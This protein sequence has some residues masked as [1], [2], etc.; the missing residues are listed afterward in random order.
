MTRFRQHWMAMD[1]QHRRCDTNGRTASRWSSCYSAGCRMEGH[2]WRKLYCHSDGC[3]GYFFGSSVRCPAMGA[4]HP[5]LLECHDDQQQ[6][7]DADISRSP[8]K[9]WIDCER[10][11]ASGREF[12]SVMVR[13]KNEYLK[14]PV[15]TGNDTNLF[16]LEALVCR[17]D[18]EK[19]PKNY[20]SPYD[21]IR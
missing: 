5:L 10:Q 14:T 6:L 8:W 2:R 16:S 17:G 18:P 15:R 1:S 19:K 21:M 7:E 12:Q 3:S 9:D 20:S 4:D 13:G 11:T